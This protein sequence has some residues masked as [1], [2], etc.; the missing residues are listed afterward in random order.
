LRSFVIFLFY[1]YLVQG[2]SLLNLLEKDASGF[3][4]K[5]KLKKDLSFVFPESLNSDSFVKAF[6]K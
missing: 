1:S 6:K 5:K 2:Q 4:I 3:S